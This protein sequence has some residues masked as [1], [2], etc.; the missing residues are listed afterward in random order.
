MGTMMRCVTDNTRAD[1]KRG[2]HRLQAFGPAADVGQ[3]TIE[4]P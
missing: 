1:D 4:S 3:T 2:A